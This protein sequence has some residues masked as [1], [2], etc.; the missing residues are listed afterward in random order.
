MSSTRSELS[1][2]NCESSTESESR[3]TTERSQ[4]IAAE[5][6]TAPLQFLPRFMV[7]RFAG[8]KP[9]KVHGC[10][11]KTTYDE[12]KEKMVFEYSISWN[13]EAPERKESPTEETRSRV[14][15]TESSGLQLSSEIRTAQ[16]PLRSSRSTSPKKRYTELLN[17]SVVVIMRSQCRAI[18]YRRHSREIPDSK[19]F[20]DLLEWI[21]LTGDLPA[22][23]DEA[24]IFLS[25]GPKY[26]PSELERLDIERSLGK[27]LWQLATTDGNFYLAI[28]FTHCFNKRQPKKS[29]CG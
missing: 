6:S 29:I 12:A 26:R 4:G 15:K 21:V 10:H 14:S 22:P 24:A 7:K 13:G 2:T 18:T 3:A 11:I 8:K 5:N 23:I 27:H 9:P 16:T 17:L 28:D 1:S 20:Y 25:K 19:L